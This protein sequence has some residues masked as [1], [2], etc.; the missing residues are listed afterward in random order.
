[1]RF[2]VICVLILMKSGAKDEK[3]CQIRVV[4]YLLRTLYSEFLLF[5]NNFYGMLSWA[6]VVSDHGYM[7]GPLF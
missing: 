4:N 2:L 5:L 6:I 3:R 7:F 1:M